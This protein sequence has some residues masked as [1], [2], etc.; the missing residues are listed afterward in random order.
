MEQIQELYCKKCVTH[1]RQHTRKP[2]TLCQICAAR[3]WHLQ[4]CVATHNHTPQYTGAHCHTLQYLRSA[5]VASP[6]LQ[7]TATHTQQR[8][9]IQCNTRGGGGVTMQHLRSARVASPALHTT[10]IWRSEDPCAIARTLTR[11]CTTIKQISI[12]MYT[13][14][15]IDIYTNI[16]K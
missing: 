1:T 16:Y 12:Y 9:Q 4:R 15:Y 13:Y 7:H 11:A 2:A 5:L 8:T 6:T 3:E 10:A 14:K